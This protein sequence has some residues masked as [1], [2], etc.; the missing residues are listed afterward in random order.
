VC[1]RPVGKE[2]DGR[3][4]SGHGDIV[5]GCRFTADGQ[6]L[7]SWS[8]DGTLRL[9]E[10]ELG[11]CAATLKAHK[12]RVVWA[13]VSADSLWAASAGRDGQLKLW[14]LTTQAQA[15]AVKLGEPRAC[16]FLLDAASLVSVDARGGMQLLSV[17][18]LEVQAELDLGVGVLCGDLA[19]SGEQVALGAEDGR[20]HFVGVEGLEEAPLVV[21]ATQSVR[22]GGSVLGRLLGKPKRIHAYQYTCPSC[23][24]AGEMAT[25]SRETFACPKCRRPLR[26][27]ARVRQL[28]PQ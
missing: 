11:R 8:H 1:I 26:M 3:T 22:P 6:Q 19:P 5:A 7:L 28:Q 21:T 14:D 27:D 12:D 2:R 17:P 16:F 13:S 9:W 23:R 20:V 18:G 4:L 10:A 25:P 24:H 15:G